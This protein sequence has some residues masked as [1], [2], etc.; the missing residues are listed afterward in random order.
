VKIQRKA[1]CE[2]IA[3][4]PSTIAL[5]WLVDSHVVGIWKQ[6]AWIFGCAFVWGVWES[7]WK[8]IGDGHH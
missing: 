3:A 2:I 7:I 5:I 8:G 4:I 6:G 1:V